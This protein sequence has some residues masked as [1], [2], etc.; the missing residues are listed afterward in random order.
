MNDQTKKQ[1]LTEEQIRECRTC[2]INNEVQKRQAEQ[3]RQLDASE[4][5]LHVKWWETPE[6]PGWWEALATA[7]GEEGWA[8]VPDLA[9]AIGEAMLD[10]MDNLSEKGKLRQSKDPIPEDV[11][12]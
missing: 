4:V 5:D 9:A 7:Q 6:E 8:A 11:K 12:P 10:L 3:A 2:P 1:P